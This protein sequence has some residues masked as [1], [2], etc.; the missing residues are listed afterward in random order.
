[1]TCLNHGRKVLSTT[2]SYLILSFLCF[3]ECSE[4]QEP[5]LPE[6]Y[7]V[8]DGPNTFTMQDHFNYLVSVSPPV[9]ICIDNHL[10][11]SCFL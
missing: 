10:W 7:G 6:E 11:S 1:M 4:L 9:G 8:D 5:A 2:S 3:D